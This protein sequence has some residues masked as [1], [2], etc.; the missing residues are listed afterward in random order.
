MPVF[1]G[2]D[3]E[4]T[5]TNIDLHE[6]CQV[7]AASTEGEVFTSD[8]RC[9][10]DRVN[11]DSMAVHGIDPGWLREGAPAKHLVDEQLAYWLVQTL[12][13][14]RKVIP[15]GWGVS[16]F[17]MPWVRK[18]LPRS[19]EYF[20]RRS[21]ELGT[22]CYTIGATF[23]MSPD[24]LKRKAKRYAENKNT[25]IHTWHNAGYDALASLLAWEYLMKVMKAGA[26]VDDGA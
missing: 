13:T 1:V 6:L 24:T 8:I 5:G 19:A 21:V 4:M 12:N 26:Y 23:G 14:R 25:D 10:L 2:L 11:P 17:D 15:V 18:Y 20:S 3:C 16:Y 22:V 7:G 9:R